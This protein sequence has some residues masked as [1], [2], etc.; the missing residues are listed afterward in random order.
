MWR[1]RSAY[2]CIG[3]GLA[4]LT[5]VWAGAARRGTRPRIGALRPRRLVRTRLTFLT[6]VLTLVAAAC[7]G[8]S[9]ATPSPSAVSTSTEN[10]TSAPTSSPD[11]NLLVTLAGGGTALGDGGPATSAG[12]CQTT[13]VALDPAGNM[14]IADAGLLCL[15]PGGNTVR[16]VDPNGIITTVAGTGETGFSGDGGPAT[17]AQLNA[18]FAVALDQAGNLYIADLFNYRVRKVDLKGIITTVAG[19]G[20]RG[21]S[22]DGGP[23][24]AARLFASATAGPESD[25]P[26]G[27]AFD[28]EGNLY[29]AD[30]GAVR[31]IDASGTI[32][33]VAGTGAWG[34][35]GD[36]GPA[37][38]ATINVWD[39]AVDRDGNLYISEWPNERIRRVDRNGVITTVAGG[40][41]GLY[42]AQGMPATSVPLHDPWGI[43]V[44]AHGNLFIAEH[45]ARAIRKVD[46]KGIIT[47]V[48]GAN[49][50]L[51]TF[52]GDDGPATGIHLNDP[53]G[54]FVDGAGVLYIADTF[55]T[56]IRAVHFPDAP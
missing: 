27:L 54:L 49:N 14:Y 53:I 18:P 51:P 55:N 33:T 34:F 6:I 37:T 12:F 8:A 29:L 46:L 24:T 35:S 20:E 28:A 40:G 13:D 1:H 52:N 30:G 11:P 3:I 9:S 38:E 45:H 43:A 5:F 15:G 42:G 56:R 47:T 36:G 50:G 26:G 23:A 17:S 48:A 41:N 32:T 2:R 25:L 44:D 16:K 7:S 22:G 4:F 31:K 39:V 21:F 10:P 19:T